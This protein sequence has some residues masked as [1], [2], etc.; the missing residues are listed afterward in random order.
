MKKFSSPYW[1]A[2]L[3]C[4]KVAH[5]PLLQLMHSFELNI[6]ICHPKNCDVLQGEV[7]GNI[8]FKL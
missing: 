1:I 5:A 2:V 8:T 4:L 6:K 7:E 3:A